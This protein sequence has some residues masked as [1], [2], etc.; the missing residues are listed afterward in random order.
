MS[1]T[2][3][4]TGANRG[5]GLEFARQ[6]LADGWTVIATAR[7]LEG[8][9]DLKA[10]AAEAGERLR[11]VPLDVGSDESV[12]AA[13]QALNDTAI[14]V[15]VNNA[16]IM[17]DTGPLEKIGPEEIA[18][19][20][21]TNV[22]GCWRV[23]RALLPAVQKSDQKKIA[24]ITSKMGS[25]GDGP[26]GGYYPYRISKSG[27]NMLGANLAAELR[28]RGVHVVILHPGWVATRMGG[29]SAP[30]TAA[31]SIAGMKKVI[32]GLGP[33]TSGR[34]FHAEGHEVPW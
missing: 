5:L 22:L 7:D 32:D 16:G 8:A 24:F 18:R 28:S 19:V 11:L 21:D 26:G 29:M 23:T 25:I 12:E 13:A 31:E 27:L 3:L 14:D 9:G 4:I 20:F 30:T 33:D 6:Y 17:G 10:L 34:F 15:L 1:A 2:A